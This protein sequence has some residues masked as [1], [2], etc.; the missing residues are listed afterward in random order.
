M[1]ETKSG[2]WFARLKTGLSRTSS[3]IADSIGAVL[4]RAT[5]DDA[6]LA[7]LEEALIAADLG[8]RVAAR[9]VEALRKEKFERGVTERAVREALAKSI[10][11]IRRV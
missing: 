6:T 9:L 4:G 1:S 7:A 8:P 5:L 11:T 10:A 3:K 2:G